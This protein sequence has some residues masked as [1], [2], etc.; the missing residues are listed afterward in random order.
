MLDRVLDS[1]TV[2]GPSSQA[3]APAKHA[4]GPKKAVAWASFRTRATGHPCSIKESAAGPAATHDR[5][6]LLAQMDML[7]ACT[8]PQSS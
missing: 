7:A 1:P 3:A 4:V 2:S 8:A 5:D 6:Q